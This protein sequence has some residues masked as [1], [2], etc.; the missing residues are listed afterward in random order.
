MRKLIKIII[1]LFLI[2]PGALSYAEAKWVYVHDGSFMS[3]YALVERTDSFH[4]GD[5]YLVELGLGCTGLSWSS[6]KWALWTG[7][8]LFL[9]G[10]G[11][12][13]VDVSSSYGGECRVW[14]AFPIEDWESKLYSW[15]YTEFFSAINSL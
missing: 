10:I 9:D 11:D 8:N 4:D 12:T 5:F 14:D 3:N 7:M 2:I 1:A 6:D 13:F 15:E